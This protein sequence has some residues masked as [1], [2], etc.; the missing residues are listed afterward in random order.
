MKE[1]SPSIKNTGLTLFTQI[2]CR[3]SSASG[4]IMEGSGNWCNAWNAHNY[5]LIFVCLLSFFLRTHQFSIVRKDTHHPSFLFYLYKVQVLIRSDQLFLCPT[6]AAKGCNSQ[7][8]YDK[9]RVNPLNLADPAACESLQTRAVQPYITQTHRNVFQILVEIQT[10]PIKHRTL[11]WISVK[12][13]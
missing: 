4:S 5:C 8:W 9:N 3:C 10:F 12:C 7:R 1:C 13:L 6:T 2:K 11:C